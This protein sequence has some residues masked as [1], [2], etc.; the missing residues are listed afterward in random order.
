MITD[1][2]STLRLDGN[3]AA[4]L[5]AE[6]FAPDVTAAELT[7]GGCGAR[8][9]VGAMPLYGGAMGAVLRCAHCDT[10]VLKL[11]R[12]PAGLRLDMHATRRLFVAARVA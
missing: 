4:A 11:T 3:A 7:C 5:F 10:A 12:T 6:L 2:P 1:R 9:A 8:A